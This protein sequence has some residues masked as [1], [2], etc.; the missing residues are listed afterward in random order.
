MPAKQAKVRYFVK[1]S[2]GSG[3]STFIKKIAAKY[4]A[5]GELTERFH[6]SNDPGSLD[7]VAVPALGFC[8]TDATA[9]H[10]RD[11]EI[12]GGIDKIIDLGQ[13]LDGEKIT[14]HMEELQN[15][16]ELKKRQ[17]EKTAKYLAAAGS[18]FA[19][20]NAL[21]NGVER[22]H[23]KWVNEWVARLSTDENPTDRKLFLSA[24][25]PDGYVCYADEYFADSTVTDLRKEFGSAAS[26]ML[27]ALKSRANTAGISTT[28]FYNPLAPTRLDYLHFPYEKITLAASSCSPH[29]SKL[30]DKVLAATVKSMHISRSFHIKLENIFVNAMDFEKAAFAMENL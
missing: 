18:I 5:D 12:P 29:Q 10:S 7:G 22:T 26:E 25:T 1:G 14:P 23:Y 6:C 2:S 16:M 30:S 4:E 9:P 17:N 8:I 20:E 3:K 13:F 11:P 28:A 21:P 15:L 24:I 19:A 27:A